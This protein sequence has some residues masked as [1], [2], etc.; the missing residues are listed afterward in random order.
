MASPGD[1]E[2]G[3]GV[4]AGEPDSRELGAAGRGIQARIR[5]PCATGEPSKLQPAGVSPEQRFT[6]GPDGS[7]VPSMDSAVGS[8][9]PGESQRSA[10]ELATLLLELA[11][12]VKARRYYGP[13]DARLARVFVYHAES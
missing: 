1:R 13:G 11:R 6:F 2:D 3:C 7:I 5:F 8:E 12:L 9:A 10:P 4:P